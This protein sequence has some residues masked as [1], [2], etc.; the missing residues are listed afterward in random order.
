MTKR[1]VKTNGVY[2]INGQTYKAVK[3]SRQMVWHGTAFKTQGL[4]VKSDLMM[5]KWGRIVFKKKH[6]T[7]KR[8]NRLKKH[9]WGTEKHKF[10]PVRLSVL[11][12]TRR[13]RRRKH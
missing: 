12:K 13:T 4:L 3:G 9:G 11:R 5:N 1:P 10:G 2:H 8:E 7:S 6:F